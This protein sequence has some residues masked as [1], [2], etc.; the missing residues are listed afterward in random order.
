MNLKSVKKISLLHNHYDKDRLVKIT[1]EMKI[2]G[3]PTIRVYDCGFEGIYQ[4]IE[5]CHRLRACEILGITPNLVELDKSTPIN[6]LNNIDT[7]Y[8]NF[9][10]IEDL[11]DWDN[12][13]IEFCDGEIIIE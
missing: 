9:T 3:A 11:G 5:G 8:D 7:D 10:T 1:D 4:A 2:L 13:Y 6:T 12:Y